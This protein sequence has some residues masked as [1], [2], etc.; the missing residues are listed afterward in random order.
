[1][2]RKPRPLLAAALEQQRR[3]AD[4]RHRDRREQERRADDRADGDVLGARAAADQGDD[5]DQRL[6]HRGP[7]R[8]EHAPGRPLAEPE[9]VA[10][11]LD[12]V[13]EQQ[14]AGE[15]DREAGEQE[16]DVHRYLAPTTR[17]R[18]RSRGSRRWPRSC[19]P[20]NQVDSPSLV[21]HVGD[22]HRKQDGSELE[23]VEDERHRRRADDVRGEHEH[24]GDEE[25]DLGAGSD[26]DVH[27]QVHLV[28][29]G[30]QHRDPVLGRVADD[31]DHD[32]A[33]E[34]L[35]EPH[36]LRGLGDRADEDLRHQADRHPGERAASQPSA[37]RSSRESSSSS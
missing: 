31:R 36:R 25:R 10:R 24:R 29:A 8:G 1:M 12:R 7:D 19:T 11:P 13:R 35:R 6:G 2:G 32:H 34:E 37:A 4:E 30:D 14:R 26:R 22:Q 16:D 17:R 5:R 20:S 23:A 9:P 28:L 18:T 27:R 21:D 33:D 15:D 3:D